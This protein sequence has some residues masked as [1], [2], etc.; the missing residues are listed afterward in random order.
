M[1]GDMA[2]IATH[3]LFNEEGHDM[4]GFSCGSDFLSIM[5]VM[6]WANLIHSP[7]RETF[8]GLTSFL[9]LGGTYVAAQDQYILITCLEWGGGKCGISLISY[10]V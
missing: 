9:P 2:S 4:D 8:G 10:H 5:C 3:S 6:D 1:E 7:G